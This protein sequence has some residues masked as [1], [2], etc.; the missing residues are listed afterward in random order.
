MENLNDLRVAILVDDGFE[1]V[2]LVEPWKALR[3]AGAKI[4]IVSPKTVCAAG[5]SR[6][7]GNS[8]VAGEPLYLRPEEWKPWR[9]CLRCFG[10]TATIVAVLVHSHQ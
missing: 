8:H 10:H 3:E 2:E 7:Q 9:R 1:E 4:R 5:I 6:R